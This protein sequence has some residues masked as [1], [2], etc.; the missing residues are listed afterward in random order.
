MHAV[1]PFSE[2]FFNHEIQIN[3]KNIRILFSIKTAERARVVL[4]GDQTWSW[5]D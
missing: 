2:I 3:T 1:N 5:Q 4:M